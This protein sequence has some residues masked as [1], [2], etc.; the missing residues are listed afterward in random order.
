MASKLLA[1]AKQDHKIQI[2]ISKSTS[3]EVC[4]PLRKWNSAI[5]T[6]IDTNGQFYLHQKPTLTLP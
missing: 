4:S 3:A 6:L 5:Q 1:A 2:K